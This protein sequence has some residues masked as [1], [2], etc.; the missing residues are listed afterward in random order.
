MRPK[1]ERITLCAR[2]RKLASG[3]ALLSLIAIL[4]GA[5]T[6]RTLLRRGRPRPVP[7]EL[8]WGRR[9]VQLPGDGYGILFH[10][11]YIVEIVRPRHSPQA[12]MRQ[13]KAELR[14]FSPQLLADFNKIKGDPHQMRVGD[15]YAIKILGPWDGNVRVSEVTPR[16]FTFVTLEGHPEAGQITFEI[17][18]APL[19][20]GAMRFEIS[21]WARSRDM[22]VSLGYH[23]GK[24][25][26]EIQKNA[27]VAFCERVVEASGGKAIGEVRVVTEERGEQGEV[28][29]VV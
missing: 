15:E 10:R 25:G 4:A 17:S 18:R 2:L 27:W 26:K 8:F 12:L 9:R 16:S 23:E 19:R 13:I 11:R 22:I 3:R 20:W 28:V 29:P 5:L 21:S 6:L 1:P 14:E 7:K 24:L